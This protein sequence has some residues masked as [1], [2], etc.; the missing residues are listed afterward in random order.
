MEFLSTSVPFIR[1]QFRCDSFHCLHLIKINSASDIRHFWHLSGS[2]CVR[3]HIK[4]DQ[5]AAN[6]DSN[7]FQWNDLFIKPAQNYCSIILMSH[8]TFVSMSEGTFATGNAHTTANL[9]DTYNIRPVYRIVEAI[10]EICILAI[11]NGQ[12]IQLCL[13]CTFIKLLACRM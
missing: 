4:L 3:A 12:K 13:S 8:G 1:A 10:T 11:R 6:S 7:L 9:I 5:H 2:C